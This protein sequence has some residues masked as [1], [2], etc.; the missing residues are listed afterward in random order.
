M[1]T[2]TGFIYQ[3]VFPMTSEFDILTRTF[4]KTVFTLLVIHIFILQNAVF[5]AAYVNSME[6]LTLHCTQPNK[7]VLATQS[8][9]GINSVGG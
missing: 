7:T 3:V 1:C 5:L 6:N 9:V 4:S 2:F 8:I